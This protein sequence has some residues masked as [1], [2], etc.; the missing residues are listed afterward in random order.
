PALSADPTFQKRF[1][2]EAK[3]AARFEHPN[4]VQV[5]DHGTDSDGT[6]Y[7]AMEFLKGPMLADVIAA[8]GAMPTARIVD[9]MSQVLSALAAAHDAG[10]VHR[11]LKPENVMLVERETDEGEKREVVKVTDFG[12]AKMVEGSRDDKGPK[13]TAAGLVAG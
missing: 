10:I 1:E 12:I 11:D 3:T 13:L 6:T 5:L 4:S 2:R 7:I 8:E 9:I